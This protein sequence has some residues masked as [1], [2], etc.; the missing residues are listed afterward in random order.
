MYEQWYYVHRLTETKAHKRYNKER[1]GHICEVAF[2][3]LK[4]LQSKT[5]ELI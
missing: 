2:R 5:V 3:K 4:D 1:R